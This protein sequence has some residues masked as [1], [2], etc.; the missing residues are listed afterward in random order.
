MSLLNLIDWQRINIVFVLL[1]NNKF[2]IDLLL[3][4]LLLL[5]IELETVLATTAPDEVASLIT[6]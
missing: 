4:L 6:P 1:Y 5:L 2:W 3:L